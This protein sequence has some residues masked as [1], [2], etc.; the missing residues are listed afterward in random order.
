MEVRKCLYCIPYFLNRITN[1]KV[2]SENNAKPFCVWNLSRG[3]KMFMYNTNR[4]KEKDKAS[5]RRN[6]SMIK[7]NYNLTTPFKLTIELHN[8]LTLAK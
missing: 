2:V 4:V 6:I 5:F 7:Q 3:Y 1:C 8:I